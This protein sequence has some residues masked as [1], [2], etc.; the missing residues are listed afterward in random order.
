[1]LLSLSGIAARMAHAVRTALRSAPN[2]NMRLHKRRRPAL[3]Y[4]VQTL[5]RRVML[6]AEAVIVPYEIDLGGGATWSVGVL[7]ITDNPRDPSHNLKI[8]VVGG[9]ISITD[10]GLP[11]AI[12]KDGAPYRASPG[13]IDAIR[14]KF[15]GGKDGTT[16]DLRAV[17]AANGFKLHDNINTLLFPAELE[18]GEAPPIVPDDLPPQV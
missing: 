16:I 7:Q 17:T 6:T 4:F 9:D 12:K 3:T 5:E 13:E 1:M 14:I 10:G 18:P 2:G 15:T 8:D 11:V